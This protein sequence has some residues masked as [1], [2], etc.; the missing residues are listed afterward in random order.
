M[1]KQQ[2]QQ[3]CIRIYT[4]EGCKQYLHRNANPQLS[5]FE[6][7]G[8]QVYLKVKKVESFN[9]KRLRHYRQRNRQSLSTKNCPFLT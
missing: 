7:G 9:P 8:A 3:S 2:R 1:L 5:N 4:E 6:G